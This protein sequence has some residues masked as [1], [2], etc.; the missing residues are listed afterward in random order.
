MSADKAVWYATGHTDCAAVFAALDD[1][2]GALRDN[3]L[4]AQALARHRAT[5]RAAVGL[6]AGQPAPLSSALT[7][8]LRRAHGGWLIGLH[9]DS[10]SAAT[11]AGLIGA[12]VATPER[13]AGG[14]ITWTLAE[15]ASPD[16]DGTAL[17]ETGVVL[18]DRVEAVLADLLDRASRRGAFGPE[19]HPREIRAWCLTPTGQ[20]AQARARAQIAG[21]LARSDRPVAPNHVRAQITR[22]AH[23]PRRTLA[24]RLRIAPV[25]HEGRSDATG[26]W[27]GPR[28]ILAQTADRARRLFISE[29][30]SR[31]VAGR[32]RSGYTPA[33]LWLQG[34]AGGG[35]FA[36]NVVIYRGRVTRE[37]LVE[38]APRIEAGLDCPGLGPFLALYHTVTV[39]PEA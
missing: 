19:H 34:D 4:R 12:P 20:A 7:F 33:A 9:Q 37:V 38:L 13:P 3:R 35:L 30:H 21:I 31:S 2:A 10:A 22:G 18:E 26:D 25:S 32:R 8:S 29:G 24:E 23:L 39:E 27:G 28:R 16:P 14:E 36:N 1:R 6:D 11:L 15:V 17:P 5:D